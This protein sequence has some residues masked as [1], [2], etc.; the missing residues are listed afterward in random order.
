MRISWTMASV[1][2]LSTTA[3]LQLVALVP[4]SSSEAPLPAGR[5][6]YVG[7]QPGDR[8]DIDLVQASG[9]RQAL[10]DVGAGSCRYVVIVS[11]TCSASIAAARTWQQTRRGESGAETPPGW[12]VVWVAVGDSA[13]SRR[14]FA[15]EASAPIWVPEDPNEF[16]DAVQLRVF[17]AHL[18]LDRSGQ[19]VSGN[20]GA[21][22]HASSAYA[23]DC[24]IAPSASSL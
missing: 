8:F 19:L 22:L 18:I 13:A 7:A 21:R 20:V 9:A 24:T 11:P 6:S 3:I 10:S 4:G 17:P 12:H 14:A 1:A 2:A 16:M 5:G 15:G 23:N